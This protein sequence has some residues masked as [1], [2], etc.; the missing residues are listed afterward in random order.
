[1]CDDIVDRL[2]FEWPNLATCIEASKEIKSLRQKL[3]LSLKREEAAWEKVAAL[4]TLL[5][6]KNDKT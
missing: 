5:R 6:E 1:M 2:C 4:E 3:D